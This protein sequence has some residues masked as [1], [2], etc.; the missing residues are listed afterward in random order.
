LEGK[1]LKMIGNI[2]YRKVRDKYPVCPYCEKELKE[3]E[4]MEQGIFRLTIVYIRPYCDKVLSMA[5]AP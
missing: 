5:V 3:I 1:N 4:Y 2:K